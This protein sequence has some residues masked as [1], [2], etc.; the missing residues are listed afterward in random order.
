M[1]KW[2]G[3]TWGAPVN[4]GSNF[5]TPGNESWPF[6]NRD[7]QFFFSSDGLPGLGGLDV[8]MA[9][10]TADGASFEAPENLGYPANSQHDDFGYICDFENKTGYLSS[11]RRRGGLDDD[12]FRFSHDIT[13]KLNGLV[14]EE[15]TETPIN[16]AQITLDPLPQGQTNKAT[17]EDGKFKYYLRAKNDYKVTVTRDGYDVVTTD[18]STQD[19]RPGKSIDKKIIL[20]KYKF[21]LEA[22]VTTH[23]TNEPVPGATFVI[24]NRTTGEITNLVTDEAGNINFRFAPESDYSIYAEKGNIKTNV[25]EISTKGKKASE[26]FKVTLT[27][28]QDLMLAVI[29]YD[30]DKA[31]VRKD[32][33]NTVELNQ[34]ISIMKAEPDMKVVAK[35]FAD[36]RG[37]DDYNDKLASKRSKAAVAYLI[38]KGIKKDRIIAQ[39]FGETNLTNKCD[40]GVEC[41]EEDHQKNR[42]TEF[43]R[44]EDAPAPAEAK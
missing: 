32:D 34:L 3:T 26:K 23:S 25:V 37:E 24:K 16:L 2:D 38:K 6:I 9:W 43:I 4:M 14:V 30:F 12:L 17:K 27:F 31:D 42:R 36:S 29:Y 18:V 5:N 19:V 15:G 10:P 13:I 33:F 40:D 35:S 21:D 41:S 22:T 44:A 7:G 39:S 11:N 20:S 28:D 8:F 1:S